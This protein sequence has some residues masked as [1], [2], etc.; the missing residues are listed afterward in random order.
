MWGE[1]GVEAAEL[2]HLLAPPGRLPRGGSALPR[3]LAGLR[4]GAG[5]GDDDD[6]VISD[7][8]RR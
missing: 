4:L 5:G 2:L 1:E 6:D 7:D 8:E 3:R